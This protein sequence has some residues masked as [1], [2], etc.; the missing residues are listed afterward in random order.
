[1]TDPDQV[2]GEFI[3]AWNTGERPRARQ[4]LARV[5][6]GPGRDELADR[7]ALWLETAP[8]PAYD[9]QAREAIRAEPVVDRVLAAGDRD[10]GLWPSVLPSLR[11]RAGLSVRDVAAR[12][13]ERFGLGAAAEPRTAD[14]LGRME[15]GD[16]EPSRVSRRLLDALGDVLGT[17]GRTLADAG[18][19]GGGPRPAGAGGMLFRAGQDAD[20]GI[21]AEIDALSRAAMAPAPAPLD[22]VDRLFLGGPDG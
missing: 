15:R 16:L 3:D 7:I 14:Y 11:A 1:M 8:T 6:D 10:A 21:A 5:P 2:L 18:Q 13:V 17:A 4:Y 19:P 22:D 20:R 12:L 9:A